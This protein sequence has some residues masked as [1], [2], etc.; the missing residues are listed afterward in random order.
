MWESKEKY[1]VDD[2]DKVADGAGEHQVVK[3]PLDGGAEAGEVDDA[4]H[5][6]QET[7]QPK[8]NLWDPIQVFVLYS[9]LTVNQ[10]IN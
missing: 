6:P 9:I 1:G 2:V 4:E 5:V 8:R 3:V 7:Q 10:S